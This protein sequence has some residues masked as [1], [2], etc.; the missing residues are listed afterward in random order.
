MTF[1]QNWDAH[2]EALRDAGM[3]ANHVSTGGGLHAIAIDLPGGHLLLTDGYGD[4]EPHDRYHSGEITAP[5]SDGPLRWYL[6]VYNADG[7]SNGHMVDEASAPPMTAAPGALVEWIKPLVQAFAPTTK[8]TLTMDGMSVTIELSKT[9]HGD[10]LLQLQ[11]PAG[12]HL[13]GDMPGSY[14]V[15]RME[16]TDAR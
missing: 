15:R 12:I 2:I 1:D 16:A 10:V 13:D 9:D 5:N 14:Y 4:L 11:P 8:A 6:G 3:D 7:D